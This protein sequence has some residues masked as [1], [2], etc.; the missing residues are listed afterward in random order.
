M[1][2]RIPTKPG[3]VQLVPVTGQTN[4]YDMT[5]ADEPTEAGTPLN[6]TTLLKDATAALFG[7]TDSAVPDDVFAAIATQ[8]QLKI[9][10]GTYTG[11]GTY[12]TSYKNSLTFGFVPKLVI[13]CPN[14]TSYSA[15]GWTPWIAGQ[16]NVR[17]RIYVSSSTVSGDFCT[18]TWSNQTIEWYNSTG[19]ER[20]LNR[21][22]VTYYYIAIG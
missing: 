12:G 17:S 10:T 22:N 3:R 1:K 18:C 8:P 7:L 4:L 9:E 20:Q 16:T 14:S 19:A 6:K 15:E 5:L 21:N 11:N 2:D 13:I